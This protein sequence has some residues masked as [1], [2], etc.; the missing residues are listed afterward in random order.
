MINKALNPQN[1][2][3]THPYVLK[4]FG[5]KKMHKKPGSV[6]QKKATQ[7][8]KFLEH[9]EAS[10]DINNEPADFFWPTEKADLFIFWFQSQS[11]LK[12]SSTLL[13]YGAKTEH[14]GHLA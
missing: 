6:L 9:N 8:G 4:I 12:K 10:Y 1:N 14:L 13:G 7:A 2:L 5:G 11:R 3:M